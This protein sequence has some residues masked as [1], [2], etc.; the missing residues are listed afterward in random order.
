M[1]VP[2]FCDAH[3]HFWDHSVPGLRWAWLEPDFSHPR[4]GAL[5]TLDRPSYTRP[6]LVAAAG[7]I[8]LDKVVHI[9]CSAPSC[10]P[11]VET[12]W[13][14]DVAA[15]T[16]WPNAVIGRCALASHDAG[17]VLEAQA[18]YPLFRGVRDMAGAA[19]GTPEFD[20]GCDALAALGCSCELMVTQAAYPTVREVAERH[21]TLPI[22][23]GHA[24]LPTDRSPEALGPWIDALRNVARADNVVIK[25]SAVGGSADPGWTVESIRPWVLGCIEAF[26]TDRAM[27]ASNWPVDSL[28]GTYEGLLAA[29]ADIVSGFSDDERTALFSAN[30]ERFYGI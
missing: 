18:A 8:T 30:T 25:I 12:A 7:A 10:D 21:P 1:S 17:R 29:Y 27:F 5:P 11:V 9:E 14:H 13:L 23:L 4:L 22:V 24:G 3:A 28:F 19:L 2:R 6:E 16:G 26:G 20:R 15:R